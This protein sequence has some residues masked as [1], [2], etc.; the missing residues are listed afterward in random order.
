[1]WEH[2]VP[3]IRLKKLQKQYLTKVTLASHLDLDESEQAA[4]AAAMAARPMAQQMMPAMMRI[5]LQ[6]SLA[7]ILN[8]MTL[9]RD[10]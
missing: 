7:S 6:T 8:M 9:D 2:W 5:V 10:K 3:P 1:M 4:A